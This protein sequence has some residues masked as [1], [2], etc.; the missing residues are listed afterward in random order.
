MTLDDY[1][2]GQR[3]A[4]TS[5]MWRAK[6]LYEFDAAISKEAFDR[7]ADF[8]EHIAPTSEVR[9][10]LRKIREKEGCKEGDRI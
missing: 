5:V 4:L 8:I 2:L 7:L 3:S 6:G 10:D 9:E 1:Y